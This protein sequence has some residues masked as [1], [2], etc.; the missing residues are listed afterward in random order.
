MV[1][2]PRGSPKSGFARRMAAC[3]FAILLML[4][5]TGTAN[6]SGLAT[7]S[8]KQAKTLIQQEKA[9]PDFVLLDIRTPTE[10]KAGHLEGAI[11]IDYYGKDFL[12]KMQALD[13]NKTYLMYCRSAN[14]ST[15]TL[16]LVKDMGFK[17]LYNMDQGINGWLK[18]GFP[19]VK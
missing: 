6:A 14:R 12:K 16:R 18:N 3:V 5:L 2:N 10:F 4:V 9:N 13:K 11:L 15:R 19:V 7:I 8:P 17:S 1:N